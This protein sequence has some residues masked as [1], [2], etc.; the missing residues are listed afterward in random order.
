MA[1]SVLGVNEAP[2]PGVRTPLSCDGISRRDTV[3]TDRTTAITVIYSYPSILLE[4][5]GRGALKPYICKQIYFA[6][7]YIIY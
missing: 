4:P 2:L 1:G 5:A 6:I 3:G 7:H